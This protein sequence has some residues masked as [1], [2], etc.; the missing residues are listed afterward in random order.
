MKKIF[1]LFALL[2]FNSSFSQTYYWKTVNLGISSDLYGVNSK[3]AVGD[4]GKIF[5][6]SDGGDNWVQQQ[7]NSNANLRAV[8]SN[9]ISSGVTVAVGLNGVI[10]RTTNNG[11]TWAA[12]NSGF[13]GDLFAVCLIGVSY[14]FAAG[15]N[16][17]ILKSTNAGLNWVQMN[18]GTTVSI[19][20]LCLGGSLFA[21]GNNG[22]VRMLQT[23]LDTTWQP[24]NI[25]LNI[26]LNSIYASSGNL[27][28]VGNN[29]NI[30]KSTNSGLS[31]QHLTSPTVYDLKSISGPWIG[32][33]SATL[34][35]YDNTSS[36]WKTFPCPAAA[37]ILAVFN[38]T[39]ILGNPYLYVA[40]KSGK[41]LTLQSD[42]SYY[43][44]N[45]NG[46][47]INARFGTGGII[48]NKIVDNGPGFEWPKGS[49]KNAVYTGG[50]TIA[51]YYNNS[52][53]MAAASYR[54]EY[55][56]GYCSQGILY[57]NTFF[58]IYKVTRG[59][60]QFTN[61]DWAQ[62][63][64]MVPYGAPYKDVNNNGVYEPAIDIPGV[65]DSKQTLFVCLTDADPTKHILGE[66]FG[67]GTLPLGADI[68]F[69]AWCYDNPGYQD[70]QFFKWVL[71]NKN[72]SAWDSTLISVVADP[73]LGFVDD[74]YIGCD[75]TRNLGYCY[76]AD[77]YDD[78]ENIGGYGINPPAVGIVF[79]NCAGADA[80]LSSFQYFNGSPACERDP[81]GQPIGAYNYMKGLKKDGTPWVIPSTSP[82]RTTKF[83]YSGDPETGA[84]WTE[85]G[86]CIQN[87]GGLLTGTQ[88]IPVPPGDRKFVMTYKRQNQ[89]LNPGDSQV[90]LAAQ[91]I[92]RGTNHLNSATRLKQLTDVA[93]QLC[94]N[95]F[96]IGIS[97]ISTEIPTKFNLFQNYPNPFNPMTNFKF[98]MPNSEFVKL[99]IYDLLGREIAVLVNEKLQAGVYSVDWDGTNYTSG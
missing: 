41:L 99:I 4:G 35:N 79:L 31:W 98:Q 30:F 92:A 68:R 43:Y 5:Y 97:P 52:L 26:I 54:G 34:L 90:V 76:N 20:C 1:I 77:N 46:N 71:K 16:G 80:V 12:V 74:D 47:N 91:L 6:S 56:L 50:L 45:L 21:C 67:G 60:N 85:F 69:T 61:Y 94:Q 64:L 22:T 19:N 58:R 11:S 53:R 66:G 15:A 40:G 81:N 63:G 38:L 82:P 78:D 62:W 44:S 65:K 70:M 8:A 37:D 88:V 49:G 23:I 33:S 24:R 32:G 3:F 86:G 83:C 27:T 84:G 96:V 95:G 36:L 42:T 17:T 72:I 51:A 39:A 18:S 25:G 28:A 48:D 89:R 59:D 9:S 57:Q 55:T 14:C 7:S 87:C 29:G 93:K 10:L 75:T 13:S 73:D 2:I